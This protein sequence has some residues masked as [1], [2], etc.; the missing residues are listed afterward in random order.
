MH[1]S[2]L[3]AGGK[4]FFIFS[5]HNPEQDNSGDG[6]QELPHAL[7]RADNITGIS[8]GKL[9]QHGIESVEKEVKQHAEYQSV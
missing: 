4:V 1:G 9:L 3:Y 6:K 5:E 8:L 2:V 7:Y